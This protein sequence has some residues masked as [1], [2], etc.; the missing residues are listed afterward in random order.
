MLTQRIPQGWQNEAECLGLD[1]EMFHPDPES[2]S[3]ADEAKQICVRCPVQQTCLDYALARNEKE[4][5]WGGLT[6]KE[7][8]RIIRHRRRSA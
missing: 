1:P 5:I 3:D 7:R 8:R 4:G 2:I 6:E